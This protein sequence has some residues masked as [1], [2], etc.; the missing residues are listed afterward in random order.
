[1]LGDPFELA[2]SSETYLRSGEIQERIRGV[3]VINHYAFKSAADFERRNRRGVLGEFSGQVIWQ[4]AHD[5]G[6]STSYLAS[7]NAVE[8]TYLADYWRRYLRAAEAARIVPPARLPNLAR[9]KPADQSSIGVEV[10]GLTAV[11]D[12]A[13][14]VNG[15]ITGTAQCH[16]AWEDRPWW[17]VDLGASC[18]VYEVRLFNRVDDPSLRQNLGAFQIETADG[19]GAW[20]VV[21]CNEG[22][23]TIGGA[24]GDPLILRL[25]QPIVAR[26][27]R[28]TALGHTC[29]QLDQVE[30]YGVPVT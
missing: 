27:L 20:G 9:G 25:A 18:L 7:L 5:D 17:E 6:S 23:A 19:D 11:E 12:A 24:D 28:V 14:A 13:G 21:Y 3:G 10:R 26:R 8:D 1:V 4:R 15:Q 29:L 2:R 16:T 22:A 30:V